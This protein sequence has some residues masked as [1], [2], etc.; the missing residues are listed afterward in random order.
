MRSIKAAAAGSTLFFIAA[1]GTVVGVIPWLITRWRLP[2]TSAAWIPAQAVGVILICVGLA[3]LVH[4]FVEFTRAR[5]VP[6]PAAPTEH[7]VVDG[8]NRFVRNP[9]YVAI[10]GA[11][12]GQALLFASVG[13]LV[14]TAVAWAI[15]ATFVRFYEE[16]TLVRLFGEE[17]A[18]Y[19]R[20]VRAW[21]PRFTPWSPAS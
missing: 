19:R 9:M 14:Y 20:N 5:G 10:V 2:E 7:L 12:I 16:P 15:A 21:L 11:L 3:V 17:Y 1:P 13:V 8:F 4:A 18:D 6:I